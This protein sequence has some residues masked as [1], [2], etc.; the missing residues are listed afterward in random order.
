MMHPSGLINR[1]AIKSTGFSLAALAILVISLSAN[2]SARAED[3]HMVVL[4][5]QAPAHWELTDVTT[6]NTF[7]QDWAPGSTWN[8]TFG[9]N[10]SGGTIVDKNGADFSAG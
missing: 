10:S 3:G 2:A 9:G 8:P 6:R 5:T 7:F 1:R 4:P